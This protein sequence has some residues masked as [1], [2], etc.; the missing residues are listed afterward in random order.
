MEILGRC[1]EVW[2]RVWVAAHSGRGVLRAV[3][4]GGIVIKVSGRERRG[5]VWRRGIVSQNGIKPISK[6]VQYRG[7][8]EMVI[9]CG[10]W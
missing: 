8:V 5:K 6:V 3:R 9:H 1:G 7:R 4:T 2:R 10:I